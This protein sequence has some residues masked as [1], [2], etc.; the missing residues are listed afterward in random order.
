MPR[1]NGRKCLV[2]LAVLAL[3]FSGCGGPSV[4]TIDGS[5]PPRTETASDAPV[6]KPSKASNSSKSKKKD[7]LNDLSPKLKSGESRR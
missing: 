6:K 5:R 7:T 4:G 1:R 2:W 3:G